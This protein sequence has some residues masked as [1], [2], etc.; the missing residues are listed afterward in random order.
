[1]EQKIENIILKS[2]TRKKK[3][4]FSKFYFY[5]PKYKNLV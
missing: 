1:M 4:F 3:I 5:F 2:K